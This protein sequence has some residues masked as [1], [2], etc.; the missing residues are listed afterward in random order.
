MST[1]MPVALQKL[2]YKNQTGEMT[3][4]RGKSYRELCKSKALSTNRKFQTKGLRLFQIHLIV[5][6]IW[7]IRADYLIRQSL[8]IQKH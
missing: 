3:D 6:L 2:A 8:G 1:T 5:L 4:Q 7:T